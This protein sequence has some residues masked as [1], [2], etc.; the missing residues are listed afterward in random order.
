MADTVD[1]RAQAPARSA[2]TERKRR[3][4]L[5]AAEQVFL[6]SG[7]LGANMDELAALSG[8]S[9]QTVY[10]YFGSKEQLFVDLV[11]SMTGAASDRVN[12]ATPSVDGVDDVDVESYLVDYAHRQ[13]A[14]VLTPRLLQLRRLVI[15]EVGRFPDLART[16]WLGGPRRALTALTSIFTGFAERGVLDVDDSA[17]AAEQFNWLLMSGPLNQAMLLGDDAVPSDAGLRAHAERSVRMFLAAH[18]HRPATAAGPTL[19]GEP[20]GVRQLRLVVEATDL[21][22]AVAFYRDT[23]GLHVEDDIRTGDARVVILD[24]GRATLELVNPEQK[25]YIDDVEVGRPV[26][27][28]IRVAFEVADTAATT[29]RLVDAGADGVAEPTRTPWESINAR[30]DAPAD[31]HITIFQEPDAT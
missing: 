28:P 6:R 17:I 31:L 30:L 9:K 14:V 12:E 11:M 4:V 2:R 7:Y 27:P 22:A 25:A 3:A 16:L 19:A 23:L 24:A 10:A 26:S 21:D 1:E 5:E 18:R 20:D 8:V 29:R 15:G 13:L